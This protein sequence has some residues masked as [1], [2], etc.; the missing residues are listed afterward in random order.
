MAV[1]TPESSSGAMVCAASVGKE[2]QAVTDILNK[3]QSLELVVQKDTGARLVSSDLENTEVPEVEKE[4]STSEDAGTDPEVKDA[5]CRVESVLGFFEKM[6][7]ISDVMEYMLPVQT[8]RSTASMEDTTET[9]QRQ[10]GGVPGVPGSFPTDCSLAE[11]RIPSP[12]G[13]DS[14]SGLLDIADLDLAAAL[15]LPRVHDLSL[16]RTLNELGLDS[17]ILLTNF[18]L[19][20][21]LP[22][23]SLFEVPDVQEPEILPPEVTEEHDGKEEFPPGDG[24]RNLN[25]SNHCETLARSSVETLD[26]LLDTPRD[27]LTAN[28]HPASTFS[29]D[30]FLADRGTLDT[31]TLPE[32]IFSAE[33]SDLTSVKKIDTDAKSSEC[34]QEN[35]LSAVCESTMETEGSGRLPSAN[36]N[37]DNRSRSGSTRVPFIRKSLSDTTLMSDAI[38]LTNESP[39]TTRSRDSTDPGWSSGLHAGGIRCE[40]TLAPSATNSSSA[41]ESQTDCSKRKCTT[42]HAQH[43]THSSTNEITDAPSVHFETVG[44]HESNQRSCAMDGNFESSQFADIDT[45]ERLT[46]KSCENLA[47]ISSAVTGSR[48][49]PGDKNKGNSASGARKHG[50]TGTGVQTARTGLGR[51][52]TCSGAHPGLG[53]QE[54]GTPEDPSVEG[55]EGDDVFHCRLCGLEFHWLEQLALH[56]CLNHQP[57][58]R[59]SRLRQVS[60]ALGTVHSCRVRKEMGSQVLGSWN[61]EA[62]ADSGLYRVRGAAVVAVCNCLVWV[63][64]VCSALTPSVLLGMCLGALRCLFILVI[65]YSRQGV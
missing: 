24:T 4:V 38:D 48:Q 19:D 13:A 15:D 47:T 30:E 60:W 6:A 36:Q 12:D 7:P 21:P 40:K 25:N 50:S 58:V 23:M 34:R 54:A 44:Q 51:T 3:Y 37:R 32:E 28:Q 26:S 42:A 11:S 2:N 59:L 8:T 53:T 9:P 46:D 55:S 62:R 33:S 61:K 16:E 5:A 10:H 29:E 43:V 41:C 31:I 17:S 22:D 45:Q 14:S 63:V 39:E 1:V 56:V 57:H 18:D 65:R 64:R 52:S 35:E 49:C 20:K 27:L